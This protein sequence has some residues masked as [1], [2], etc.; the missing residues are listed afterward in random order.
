MSEELKQ[1]LT[2][3][4]NFLTKSYSKYTMVATALLGIIGTYTMQLE[5]KYKLSDNI[6]E[7]EEKSLFSFLTSAYKISCK[8]SFCFTVTMFGYFLLNR[9]Q[10]F[11]YYYS[12]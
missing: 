1:S 9:D 7:K 2:P 8:I 11:I 4:A 3:F 10:F 6:T 12:K 5:N